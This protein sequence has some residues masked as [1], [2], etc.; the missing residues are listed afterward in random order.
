ML[1]G[2]WGVLIQ[3][4]VRGE[5]AYRGERFR[6]HPRDVAGDPDL[7]NLTRPGGRARHPPTLLRG[8]RR[9]RDDEHVHRDAHRPGRLRARR[10]R[11]RDEPRGRAARARASPTSSAGFVAGL[12]RPAQRHALALAEGRRPGVPRGHVR[13]GARG[14]RASRCGARRGRRRHPA[15]RDDLRHA[16]REG[17]DR[18]RAG[19]GAG[20]AALALV[21]RD[22]HERPQPLGADGRGVLDVGRA[23]ASRSIVG[24]NCSLGAKEMRPFVED[25]A[26]VAPTYVAC[27]P[28]AGLPNEFGAPRRAAA[29][30]E[31]RTC[32]SSR[33][34]ASSTSSAAAAARRPSTSGRSWTLTRGLSPT[35]CPGEAPGA[36]LQRPRAVR[37]RPG[38]GLRDD[39]RADERHRLGALPP[40]RRGGRLRRRA[41][42]SRSSRCAA[43]PTSST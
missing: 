28:N 20:A 35:T 33:A 41:S 43:A 1:D 34:T 39:R 11:A 8:R 25:L 27:H 9:H 37:D 21:H 16:E 40:A 24:V 18:R 6:D 15:D 36:A 31:P 7:L 42:T 38:H 32:A 5:E 13:R 17:R 12:G 30:H 4:D 26:R 2:S 22:R 10:S 3:R 19:G 14:V 23:R 29:R